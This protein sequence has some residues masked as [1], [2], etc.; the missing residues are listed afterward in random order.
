MFSLF[1]ACARAINKFRVD[2]PKKVKDV[3]IVG[4]DFFLLGLNGKFPMI[5][6]VKVWEV[7]NI[8]KMDIKKCDFRPR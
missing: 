2:T 7:K 3:S 1:L 5:L 8:P 4:S 6:L